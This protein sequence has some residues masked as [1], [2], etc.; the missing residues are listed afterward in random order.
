MN[1]FLQVFKIPELR[2]KIFFVLAVLAIFRLL[3]VTPVPDIDLE[4]LRSFF[5]SNQ[6]F[7]LLNIFSGGALE[8]MSIAM[9][10]VGPYIT[11]TIIL[12]LLTM[13]F[14]AMKA[15]YYEEGAQGRRK[16]NQYS[17]W[18]T[19]PLAALQSF[20]FLSLLKN[21]G[22]IS[23]FNIFDMMSVV[24]IVTAGS[25]LLMWL[26]EIMGEKNIGNGVSLI[27]FAGILAGVPNAIRQ[28]LL[29]YDPT[30]I[31]A[32]IGFL[33]LTLV[34]FWGVVFIT[35]AERKIPVTY[36]KR[37]RGIRM[38]GGAASYLP[39]RINQAGVI[40][41]IF[42][43]SLMLLPSMLG[44]MLSITQN[45]VALK[46]AVFMNQMFNNLLIYGIIYFIL[47]VVFTYFYTAIT[48]EPNEIAK[49]L[50]RSGGFVPGIRPGQETAHYLSRI[51]V[52]ITLL[53]AVFLGIIAVLPISV[54]ALTGLKAL[55]L[56]GTSLLIVVSVAIETLRQI[57]SQLIMRRYEGINV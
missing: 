31:P 51:S 55:Q 14:P 48:F 50:Q 19:V 16:F 46:V 45:P 43:I 7:G 57:D 28:T 49:N 34:V 41:I 2:N 27:I 44:Q 4:R 3:A 20:A 54:Q 38:F 37:V 47:V 21:Q 9:L 53:G 33:A 24:L 13:I 29:T 39:L 30:K 36:A 42:A 5:G 56:G 10:G 52:R 11:A 40:P 17:R 6:V 32:I 22:I 26:G 23:F 8:N 15:L 35:E 12:Q 1:K 18:L 25:V